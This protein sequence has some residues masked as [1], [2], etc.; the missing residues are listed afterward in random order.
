MIRERS[1]PQKTTVP[2]SLPLSQRYSH[3]RVMPNAATKKASK[4]SETRWLADEVDD[5]DGDGDEVGFDADPFEELDEIGTGAPVATAPT[6][7][8][9]G[10]LSE[11]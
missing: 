8:V 2:N 5:E 3:I 1:L 11:A 10:P 7:P 4:P 6:P 9:T